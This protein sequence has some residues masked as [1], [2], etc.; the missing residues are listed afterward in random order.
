[1]VIIQFVVVVM[2]YVFGVGSIMMQES[3]IYLHAILFMIGAGYTL[4]YGGHVRVDIFYRDASA[5][6]KAILDLIG[7]AVFLLPVCILIWWFSWRYVGASW[8]V[9]E[10]SKETSGIQAVFLLKST[11]LAFAALMGLQG[12][13]LAIHSI[14]VLIGA[15]P[16]VEQS[17]P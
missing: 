5:R 14:L 12:I 8:A 15:E 3:V 9:F 10:G 4:L 2:R 1:M 7:I 13:S 11:I 17:A 6:G 16:P